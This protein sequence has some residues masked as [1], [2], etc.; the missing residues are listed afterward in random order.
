MIEYLTITDTIV[1]VIFCVNTGI[2]MKEQD[3]EINAQFNTIS[4]L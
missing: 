4:E 2:I 1:S 3:A